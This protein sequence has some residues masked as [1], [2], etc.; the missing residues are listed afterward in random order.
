MITLYHLNNSRSQRVLWLL[1]EIG[2]EYQL[3]SNPINLPSTAPPL[4]FPSIKINLADSTIILSESGAICE[5]LSLDANQLIPHINSQ[6]DQANY[7]YWKNFIDASFMESLALR[8]VFR[9]IVKQTP[10]LIKPISLAF[11]FGLEKAYITP[12]IA[13]QLKLIDQQLSKSTW[14]C[15]DH[16]TYLDIMLWFPLE[17]S[18]V[19]MN[20]AQLPNIAKYLENIHNRP[21]FKISQQKGNWSKSLFYEYWR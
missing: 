5:F 11:N 20:K 4:K 7:C 12:R 6:E 19:R 18:M 14:I 1:E 9:Q 2:A 10:F 13:Q 21:S 15:G 3:K 16:L 17:A 8:Q